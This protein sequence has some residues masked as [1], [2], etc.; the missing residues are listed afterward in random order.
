MAKLDIARVTNDRGR[1]FN[2]TLVRKGDA[3]GLNDCL[4]HNKPDPMIEFYDATYEH[5]PKF[6]IGRGQFVT[7]YYLT[8]LTGEDR[9]SS[10]RA[11]TNG[12]DLMGH[13]PEWKVTGDNVRTAV[14]S[15]QRALKC[16]S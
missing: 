14:E 2:V 9:W 5:D 8:T 16:E 7:R 3:Y 11:M 12:L 1:T 15:A 10:G 13:V 4:T 6:E